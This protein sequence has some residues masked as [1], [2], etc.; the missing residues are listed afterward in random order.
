MDHN[1]TPEIGPLG[2]KNNF[3]ATAQRVDCIAAVSPAM[4]AEVN[5]STISRLASTC[6]RGGGATRNDVYS[7]MAAPHLIFKGD[8]SVL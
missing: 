1:F 4:V 7:K 6:S 2:R 5:A 3:H 8:R